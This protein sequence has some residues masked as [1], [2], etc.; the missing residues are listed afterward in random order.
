MNLKHE[1]K[2]GF[3]R[4]R[5]KL[6]L[7]FFALYLFLLSGA[8][9]ITARATEKG[10]EADVSASPSPSPSPTI[11]ENV[12]RIVIDPGHGGENEGGKY[13]IYTEKYMNMVVANAMKEELEK[14]EGIAVYMTRTEDVDMSLEERAAY[15]DEVKADFFFCLHFNT[16]K[17]HTLYGSEVW[18]S[19]FNECYA[20]GKTFGELCLNELDSLELYR[21]GVKTRLNQKGTDYYGVI[22]NCTSYGIPSCIIEH[23]HI[24]HPEDE[25]RYENEEKLKALGVL[26][27]TAVAKFYGLSSKKLGVNYKN[28]KKPEV[29]VPT[30]VVK[31]DDTKPERV[32]LTC[33][34]VKEE[35]GEI[36]ILLTGEDK[37][38]GLLY[39]DYSLNGGKTFSRLQR[40]DSGSDSL[41]TTIQAASAEKINL[42]CRVYNGY[43]LYTETEMLEIPSFSG[44]KTDISADNPAISTENDRVEDFTVG[45]ED[46][47]QDEEFYNGESNNKKENVSRTTG[48]TE[49]SR[50]LLIL[51]LSLLIALLIVLMIV[52][53]A[54]KQSRRKKRH[55]RRG[56]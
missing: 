5:L 2:A 34:R 56:R 39:Y 10:A 22:K 8:G 13:G 53:T 35:T 51:V 11:S 40:W 32:S 52:K 1:N 27:A 16:S 23:C 47:V 20:E 28:F 42:V 15:A 9:N 29:P 46:S 48:N 14:Y 55:R 4:S 49:V 26:D 31:P 7:F 19:A 36:N 3:Q 6:Y 37:D 17:N 33:L 18:V 21:R 45:E 38:S 25:G 12:I 43:D 30:D 41:E 50:F 44:T 54:M 24:D